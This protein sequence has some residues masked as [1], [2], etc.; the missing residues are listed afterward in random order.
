MEDQ[1]LSESKRGD[2]QDH[3]NNRKEREARKKEVEQVKN[4]AT[5]IHHTRSCWGKKK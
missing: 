3:E 2:L 5:C 1:Q 4:K